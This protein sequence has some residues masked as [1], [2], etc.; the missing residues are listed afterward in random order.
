MTPMYV[1]LPVAFAVGLYRCHG[2]GTVSVNARARGAVVFT[3][4]RRQKLS[5]A[6][7]R[8]DLPGAL[9]FF[10]FFSLGRLR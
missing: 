2:V 4:A 8:L 6:N 9:K 10:F 3:W 5:D 1:G 7:N